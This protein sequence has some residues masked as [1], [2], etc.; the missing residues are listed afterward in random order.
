MQVIINKKKLINPWNHCWFQGTQMSIAHLIGQSCDDGGV[1][2]HSKG[3]D[4]VHQHVCWDFVELY[5]LYK[6]AN[7]LFQVDVRVAVAVFFAPH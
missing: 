6:V 3:V 4:L 5:V 2:Y 7:H 1:R